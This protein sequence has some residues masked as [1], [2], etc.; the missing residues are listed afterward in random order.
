MEINRKRERYIK[1][2][3]RVR[4]ILN[5]LSFWGV[6]LIY[7]AILIAGLIYALVGMSENWLTKFMDENV[8]LSV[9]ILL[10]LG[11]L[12]LPIYIIVIDKIDKEDAKFCEYISTIEGVTADEMMET[13]ERYKLTNMFSFALKKR[14]EELGIAEVPSS[15]TDGREIFRLP[16]KDDLSLDNYQRKQDVKKVYH[17]QNGEYTLADCVYTEN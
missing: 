15:C 5:T 1:R 4:Y 9:V 8:G 13:A 10:V 6:A 7:N 12:V 17:K 11:L 3:L 16:T 14:L 2:V